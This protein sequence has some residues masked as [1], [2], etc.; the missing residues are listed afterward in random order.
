VED[1]VLIADLLEY[2]I[3]PIVPV[4]K[5]LFTNLALMVRGET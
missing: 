5:E 3:L 4:Y 2:E 1:F